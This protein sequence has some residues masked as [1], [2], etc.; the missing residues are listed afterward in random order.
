MLQPLNLLLD[1]AG[2]AMRARLFVV[3]AE[4]GVEEPAC[5]RT[6][7][8]RWPAQHI[9]RRRG[10]GR[11]VYEG[12]AFRASPR[13]RDRAE[14]FL[15]L[16]LEM[17]G[18]RSAAAAADAEIAGLAW[19]A[20]AAGGRKDLTLLAGRRR[21]VRRLHRRLG[22]ARGAGRAAEARRRPPA[23]AEA[24]LAR[25]GEAASGPA[26]AAGSPPCS[27]ACREAEAAALLEELWALAGIE[28]VGGR[29]AG[30][31]AA[32][33]GRARGGRRRARR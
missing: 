1:L 5:A 4:G 18:P 13:R 14:E 29:G 30:E 11:Y 32:P 28:P 26:A 27:P 15:Q 24:E 21:P 10:S 9:E 33:P 23:A 8:S 7:P 22:A 6:S 19:R 3:Q 25:A 17:I 31:I 2:E 16:G 20:A 12:K